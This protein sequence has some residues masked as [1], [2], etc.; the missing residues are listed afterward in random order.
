MCQLK[1]KVIRATEKK[2]KQG[3]KDQANGLK[4]CGEQGAKILNKVVR[5]G[6]LEKVR[7]EQRLEGDEVLTRQIHGRSYQG[8]GLVCSRS[9]MKSA[10][11]V[12]KISCPLRPLI[13]LSWDPP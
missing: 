4:G 11:P 13:I 8:L 3:K 6:L 7:S 9:G 10:W 1:S 2:I 12:G 5:A